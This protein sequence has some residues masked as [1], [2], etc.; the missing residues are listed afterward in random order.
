M[1]Q[2]NQNAL[3]ETKNCG[4]RMMTRRER[5]EILETRL[6]AVKEELCAAT[7]EEAIKTA[8]DKVSGIMDE[9]A[10]DSQVPD[11]VKDLVADIS[12]TI[13]N[14]KLHKS[15]LLVLDKMLGKLLKKAMQII[16]EE[17]KNEKSYKLKLL[18]IELIKHV[19]EIS[20][21]IDVDKF[22]D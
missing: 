12:T 9:L 3:E 18:L 19:D 17:R 20:E 22:F 7:T 6:N 16:K 1:S 4:L 5:F 10:N 21:I 13:Q 14:V 15:T 8:L 11:D 2:M